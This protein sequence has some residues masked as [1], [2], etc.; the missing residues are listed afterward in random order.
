VGH[1]FQPGNPGG[2]GRPPKNKEDAYL[3]AMREHFTPEQAVGVIDSLL[4]DT[5]SWR[6]RHA[7]MELL[8]HYVLGKPTQRIAHSGMSTPDEWLAALRREPDEATDG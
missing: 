7:G 2:P 5:Q 8:L 1:R 4:N 6:A 3:N